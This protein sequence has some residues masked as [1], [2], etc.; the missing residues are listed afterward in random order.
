MNTKKKRKATIYSSIQNLDIVIRIHKIFFVCE[1]QL[2]IS[3]VTI[4]YWVFFISI[5]FVRSLGLFCFFFVLVYL[6][7][8]S[9]LSSLSGYSPENGTLGQLIWP[10]RKWH[11]GFT[12][13]LSVHQWS[14]LFYLF[15]YSSD[16]DTLGPLLYW[17]YISG[18]YYSIYFAALQ[19]QHT[20]TT[21]VLNVDTHMT[22]NSVW[23]EALQKWHTGTT[24]IGLCVH[25][26]SALFRLSGSER[27]YTRVAVSAI[28]SS[29]L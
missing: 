22:N 18:L 20:G 29:L 15:G 12:F 3:N 1:Y 10:P 14:I 26:W 17:L 16:N 2:R 25:Q 27:R 7:Q 21:Y 4:W 5:G 9:E 13:G 11:T 28:S 6:H 8:W 24:T 23:L 19:K